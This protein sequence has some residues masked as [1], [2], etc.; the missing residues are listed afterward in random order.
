MSNK[1][2]GLLLDVACHEQVG[3]DLDRKVSTSDFEDLRLFK[4]GGLIGPCAQ[5][6]WTSGKVRRNSTVP[7]NVQSLPVDEQLFVHSKVRTL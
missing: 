4:T 7:W 5:W 2:Q 3:E 1:Q 6:R